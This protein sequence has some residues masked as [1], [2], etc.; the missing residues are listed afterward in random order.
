MAGPVV[1]GFLLQAEACVG[2]AVVTQSTGP[3]LLEPMSGVMVV[4]FEEGRN[5]VYYLLLSLGGVGFEFR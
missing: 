5:Q 2:V 4:F 1:N 3:S